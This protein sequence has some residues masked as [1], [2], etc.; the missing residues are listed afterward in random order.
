MS[1]NNNR[2]KYFPEE[3]NFPK[4]NKYFLDEHEELLEKFEKE[5]ELQKKKKVKQKN[6]S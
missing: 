5:K 2:L 6:G 3:I 1:K 4:K